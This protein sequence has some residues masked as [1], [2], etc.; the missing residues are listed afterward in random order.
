MGSSRPPSGRLFEDFLQTAFVAHPYGNGIIG[1]RSDLE[2]FSR[3]QAEAFRKEHYVAKNMAIAV[4]GDVT[5]AEVA[6][7]LAKKYFSTL[8][9]APAPPPVMTVE[10]RQDVE[11]RIMME[12]EEQPLVFIGWHMPD[13][14]DP[15]LPRLRSPR[16][17]RRSGPLEPSL[18]DARQG[19][20]A[21]RAE[22]HVRRHARRE[23][24]EPDLWLH[25][26]GLP[27]SIPT[28]SSPP[29]T[30]GRQAS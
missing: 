8:S 7:H 26:P 10:P 6:E 25:R 27:V 18:H 20:E 15:Q 16:R 12:A 17:R 24:S 19:A 21:R 2:S 29:S 28:R 3:E 5:G 14:N 13:V 23:V 30:R 11:R 4:V 9:D 1:H 22:R